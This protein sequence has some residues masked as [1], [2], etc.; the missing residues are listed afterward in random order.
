MTVQTD[1]GIYTSTNLQGLQVNF[2]PNIDFNTDITF[3]LQ[4]TLPNMIFPKTIQLAIYGCGQPSSL[5]TKA[6]IEEDS[7]I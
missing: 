5:F 1:D 6:Q 2:Q 3:T 7:E 4:T